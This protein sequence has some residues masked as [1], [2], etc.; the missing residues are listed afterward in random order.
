MN[1]LNKI[2]SIVKGKKVA[3]GVSFEQKLLSNPIIDA[4]EKQGNLYALSTKYFGDVSIRGEKS[5]DYSVFQ[6]IFIDQEYQLIESYFQLNS[7][8]EKKVIFDVGANIG[9]TTRY[10]DASIENA[11]YYCIEPDTDNFK[12]LSENTESIKEKVHLFNNAIDDKPGLKFNIA[13]DFRDGLDWAKTTKES[14]NGAIDGITIN[15]ILEK[16]KLE[17]IDFLKIDI[18]GAERFL[19]SKESDCSYL[20]KV[21]LI[22]IEIH[23]E[24]EC[25][26]QIHAILKNAGFAIFE[27]GET[28]IGF[29]KNRLK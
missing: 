11:I 8:E 2:K 13:D 22:A 19:F 23:D 29:N 20:D 16:E 6:Q 18:E 5:S 27:S 4:V 1:K 21:K 14:S 9:F 12:L 15:E 28:T 26:E 25:R 3:Q 7:K 17:E 10:F 24:F